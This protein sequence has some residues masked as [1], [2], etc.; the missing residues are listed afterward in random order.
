MLFLQYDFSIFKILRQEN[1]SQVP[2]FRPNIHMIELYI[3]TIVFEFIKIINLI[4]ISISTSLCMIITLHPSLKDKTP[5]REISIW[6]IERYSHE[7]GGDSQ[8]YRKYYLKTFCY[9]ENMTV[10]CVFFLYWPLLILFISMCN[11]PCV[12]KVMKI[13]K[14][15]LFDIY[16][17][18]HVHKC[19]GIDMIISP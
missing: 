5:C 3:A 14:K 1:S 10:R 19:T 16:L 2:E 15:N 13:K 11:M 17:L 7:S 18:L 4:C 9:C 6:N 12:Y 8:T